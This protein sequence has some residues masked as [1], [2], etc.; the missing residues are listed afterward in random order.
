MAGD[1]ESWAGK[2]LSDSADSPEPED[3]FVDFNGTSDA[4]IEVKND[5]N[6]LGKMIEA[7]PQT[8]SALETIA[9]QKDS[10]KLVALYE[11]LVPDIALVNKYDNGIPFGQ[12]SVSKRL[13]VAQ[14]LDEKCQKA[15]QAIADHSSEM[16]KVKSAELAQSEDLDILDNLR[17]DMSKAAVHYNIVKRTFPAVRQELEIEEYIVRL[18]RILKVREELGKIENLLASDQSRDNFAELKHSRK[19]VRPGFFAGRLI[20]ESCRLSYKEGI[21]RCESLF[22]E[23]GSYM[24]EFPRLMKTLANVKAQNKMLEECHRIISDYEQMQPNADSA[25]ALKLVHKMVYSV[26]VPSEQDFTCVKRARNENLKLRSALQEVYE[27]AANSLYDKSSQVLANASEPAEPKDIAGLNSALAYLNS[28]IPAL[29]GAR[30]VFK[31]MEKKDE[32]ETAALKVDQLKAAG[33]KLCKDREDYSQFEQAVWEAKQRL[34]EAENLFSNPAFIEHDFKM[35]VELLGANGIELPKGAVFA[36]PVS[37]Y[38]QAAHS[39]QQTVCD[40]LS[41]GIG[42]LVSIYEA[43]IQQTGNADVDESAIAKRIDS[44]NKRAM[45]LLKRNLGDKIQFSPDQY[46]ERLETALNKFKASLCVI[47]QS[48]EKREDLAHRIK[49]MNEAVTHSDYARID[50]YSKWSTDI[51]PTPYTSDVVRDYCRVVMDLKK[52][53]SE[54]ASN[55][56]ISAFAHPALG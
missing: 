25:A 13:A 43:P 46:T 56:S 54:N 33:E 52:I 51:K 50:A 27:C 37:D 28:A 4:F 29:E 14:S 26:P 21:K 41:K 47:A 44:I 15:A 8:E 10:Q 53:A 48:K 38:V 22:D 5:Y 1:F 45:P 32:I 34:K 18:P 35:A 31:V 24:K 12:K 16:F 55:F 17:A 36:K 49:L 2:K 11:T 23:I 3:D 6:Q 30:D 19:A 40:K 7:L 20:A 42:A 39:A 9:Q